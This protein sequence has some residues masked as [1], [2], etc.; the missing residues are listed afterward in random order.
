MEEYR[1]N[2]VKGEITRENYMRINNTN[3]SAEEV[4]LMIKEKFNF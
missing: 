1:L 3:L 2:S 4:A